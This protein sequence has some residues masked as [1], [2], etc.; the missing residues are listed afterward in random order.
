MTN[1]PNLINIPSNAGAAGPPSVTTGPGTG[2][3]PV[4]SGEPPPFSLAGGTKAEAAAPQQPSP[5]QV[6]TPAGGFE[7]GNVNVQAV[8][9]QLQTVQGQVGTSIIQLQ[10]PTLQQGGG[11]KPSTVNLLTQHL[12]NVS[13]NLSSV[14][15]KLGMPPPAQPP[16]PTSNASAV[17]GFLDYL[18]GSQQQISD[19]STQLTSKGGKL[20][21]ADLLAVQLKMSGVQQQME[22]FSVLLGKAVDNIKTV[23]NIQN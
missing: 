14:M 8:Q 11:L 15:T 20:A 10:D 7:P 4:P 5:M 3:L 2:G 17:S 21:P 16:V 1:D 19:L 6:G 22:F 13:D 12:S 23:M 18:T 9:Q